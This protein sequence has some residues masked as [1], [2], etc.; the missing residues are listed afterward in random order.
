MTAKALLLAGSVNA[1][2][3]VLLGAFGAHA[4]KARLTAELSDIWGTAVQYH[5]Y[6][7]LGLLLIG[8]LALHWPASGLLRTSGGVMLAG[9]I[10]FSGSLYLLTLTGIRWLGAITPLGGSLLIAAWVLL[11]VAILRS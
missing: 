4:L 10:I 7:A 3:C 11:C 8:V 1:A 5:F 9:M 6:H 2:L